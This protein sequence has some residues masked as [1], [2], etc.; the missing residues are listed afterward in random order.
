MSNAIKSMIFSLIG[1]VVF[2]IMGLFLPIIQIIATGFGLLAAISLVVFVFQAIRTR[3]HFLKS[4]VGFGIIAIFDIVMLLTQ[5]FFKPSDYYL[6]IINKLIL[7][8]CLVLSFGFAFLSSIILLLDYAL[9]L[10]SLTKDRNVT[11]IKLFRIGVYLTYIVCGIAYVF[12]DFPEIKAISQ[13]CLFILYIYDIVIS[14]VVIAKQ[15]TCI[16]KVKLFVI[17]LLSLIL[18]LGLLGY[19]YFIGDSITKYLNLNLNS[20]YFSIDGLSMIVICKIL[21]HLWTIFILLISLWY[22]IIYIFKPK[23][24]V[25]FCFTPILYATIGL[26]ISSVIYY[27]NTLIPY[28]ID[29]FQIIYN[30]AVYVFAIGA[31]I[32]F[33][34]A[35]FKIIFT[36][37]NTSEIDYIDLDNK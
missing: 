11:S 34:S 17:S 15:T 10:I 3:H 6:S 36:Q 5:S 26:V 30:I 32:G 21:C 8:N 4:A 2:F 23:T 25:I 31:G 20:E 28:Y 27:N 14:S 1:Y 29:I 24:S 37:T 18:S 22:M 35:A 9:G 19:I 7:N 13:V 33:M 12:L 16:F